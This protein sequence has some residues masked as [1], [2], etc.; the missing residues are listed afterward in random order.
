MS[1]DY[2]ASAT[3]FGEKVRV[4]LVDE[5]TDLVPM[6][7]EVLRRDLDDALGRVGSDAMVARLSYKD[8][9]GKRS[10]VRLVNE[11]R[12]GNTMSDLN[13]PTSFDRTLESDRI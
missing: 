11:F 5:Y 12:R 4:R 7:A 1:G 9:I 8:G 13:W 3:T 10:A 6:E 2:R